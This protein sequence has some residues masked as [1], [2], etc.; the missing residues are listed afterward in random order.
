M[1]RY[2][3]TRRGFLAKALTAFAALATGNFAKAQAKPKWNEAMELTVGLEIEISTYGR[4]TRPYVVVW[5]ENPDGK[6][7]RNVSVW[8][9]KT[10]GVS[11]I[12]RLRRWIRSL[13]DYKPQAPTAYFIS[14]S[15]PTREPGKYTVVWDGKDDNKNLVEQGDYYVCVEVA[16][17]NGPYDLVR[18]KFTF[19]NDAFT[20]KLSG[21]HDLKEVNLEYGKK[22]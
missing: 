18:D 8:A 1:H 7:V 4:Y 17:E 16:R 13:T 3:N 22:K 11:Y 9:N 14:I 21:E 12:D 15:S 19:D 10:R 6:M 20:K 2:R 5:I